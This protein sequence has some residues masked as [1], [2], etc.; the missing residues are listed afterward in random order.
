MIAYCFIFCSV[1]VQTE[2][3]GIVNLTEASPAIPNN[4]VDFLKG[5]QKLLDIAKE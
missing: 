2:N 3:G 1:G 5:G 4:V